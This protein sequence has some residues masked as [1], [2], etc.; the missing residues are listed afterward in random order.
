MSFIGL[1]LIFFGALGQL[2]INHSRVV[3]LIMVLASVLFA[4]LFCGEKHIWKWF[5]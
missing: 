3:S 2:L 4:F 1:L 5:L